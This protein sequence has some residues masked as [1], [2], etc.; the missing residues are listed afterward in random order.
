MGRARR[1]LG[2]TEFS[3]APHL[4]HPFPRLYRRWKDPGEFEEETLQWHSYLQVIQRI[5]P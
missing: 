2:L 3:R 1:L 5:L 4:V